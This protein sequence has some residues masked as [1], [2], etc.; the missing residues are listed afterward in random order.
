MSTSS[1]LSAAAGA[2]PRDSY[3]LLLAQRDMLQIEAD[4]I[5]SELISSGPNGG[6]I[7]VSPVV[8]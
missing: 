3:K 6:H 5:H 8:S 2:N 1:T 7:S 4:A